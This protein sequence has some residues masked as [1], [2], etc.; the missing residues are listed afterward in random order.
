[1]LERNET[2]LSVGPVKATEKNLSMGRGMTHGCA[3]GAVAQI[4][5]IVLKWLKSQMTCS[6]EVE[7]QRLP[8]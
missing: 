4:M 6:Q 3:K 2:S 5:H 1:M 8:R 7:K